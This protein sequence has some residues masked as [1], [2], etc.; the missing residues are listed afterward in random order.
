MASQLLCQLLFQEVQTWWR[1]QQI[2]ESKMRHRLFL[3]IFLCSV[4]VMHGSVG[5]GQEKIEKILVGVA[6]LSGA[7]AHAFIPKDAGLYEK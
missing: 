7:L 2:K 5:Y 4:A 6:G 1:R 3:T